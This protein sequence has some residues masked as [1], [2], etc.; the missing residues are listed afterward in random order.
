ML[1]QFFHSDYRAVAVSALI[2]G[3]NEQFLFIL[4]SFLCVSMVIVY[5]IYIYPYCSFQGIVCGF[6]MSSM[7]RKIYSSSGVLLY[8]CL[9]TVFLN[10]QSL[11]YIKLPAF[12]FIGDVQVLSTQTGS[13]LSWLGLRFQSEYTKLKYSSY[14]LVC[15]NCDDIV[16]V[17]VQTQSHLQE[18]EA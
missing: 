11:E 14:Y 17:H 7:D 18:N 5:T 8:G 15:V 3:Q 9:Y 13:N 2:D 6:N 1:T 10:L 16:T 12:H 4:T